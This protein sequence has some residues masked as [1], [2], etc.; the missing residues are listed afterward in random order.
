MGALQDAGLARS[1]GVCNM[2]TGLLTD[3]INSG[4][5]SRAPEV[6]Q[7]EMHPYLSQEKLLRFCRGR[8]IAVTAF[9]PLGAGSC[10]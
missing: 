4:G 5:P 6:L 7:V 9:S 2:T 3:L 8:G 10:A 1:L